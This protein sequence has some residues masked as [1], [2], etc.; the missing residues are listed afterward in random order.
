MHRKVKLLSFLY[1]FYL[2]QPGDMPVSLKLGGKEGFE[3]SGQPGFPLFRRQTADLS[4]IM[5]SRPRGGEGVMALGSPDS[6]HLVGGDAHT[7]ARTAYQYTEVEITLNDS[8]AD[9]P[10][11]IRV[12]NRVAGI[13]AEILICIT[14]LGNEFDDR[15]FDND[16][17]VVTADCDFHLFNLLNSVYHSFGAF[18]PVYHLVYFQPANEPLADK[19][20]G[21]HR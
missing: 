8:F 20:G 7:D 4:V 6:L 10:G 5:T 9:L 13:T 14:G 18:E 1:I 15:I 19:L 2:I 11:D 3:D 17:P 16:S 12:V 21:T